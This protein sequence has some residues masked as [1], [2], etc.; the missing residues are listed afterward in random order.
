MKKL[1]TKGWS[2]FL[3]AATR[4]FTFYLIIF[5]LSNLVVDYKRIKFGIQIRAINALMPASFEY[6]VKT[7]GQE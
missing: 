6:L 2:V 7:I 3:F 5:F 4:A 1:F